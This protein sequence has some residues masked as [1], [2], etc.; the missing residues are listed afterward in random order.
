MLDAKYSI[1]VFVPFFVIEPRVTVFMQTYYV[2]PNLIYVCYRLVRYFD[3][4][5]SRVCFLTSSLQELL[6]FYLS[7][8]I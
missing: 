5:D 2:L 3:T 7:K 8:N 1:A 6:L 4:S